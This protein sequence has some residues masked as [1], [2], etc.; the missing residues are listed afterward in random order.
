MSTNLI[1]FEAEVEARTKPINTLSL[2]ME[3]LERFANRVGYCSLHK[4]AGFELVI[5]PTTPFQKLFVGF[6]EMCRW[7][8]TCL[9]GDRFSSGFLPLL[10]QASLAKLVDKVKLQRKKGGNVIV[11]CNDVKLVT[12][13]PAYYKA[14]NILAEIPSLSFEQVVELQKKGFLS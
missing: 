3:S 8:N 12:N 4:M 10:R 9:T 6:E 7:H 13:D 2:Q 5:I 1:T 14:A 11:Q